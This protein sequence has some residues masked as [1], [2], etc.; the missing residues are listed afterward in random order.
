MDKNDIQYIVEKSS[1]DLKKLNVIMTTV[2]VV[3]LI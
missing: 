1:S 2:H 3:F